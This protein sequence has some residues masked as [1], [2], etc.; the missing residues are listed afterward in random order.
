V[1]ERRK[2]QC[3]PYDEEIEIT[4]FFESQYVLLRAYDK[5]LEFFDRNVFKITDPLY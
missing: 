3:V 4:G 1:R 5:A 2:F